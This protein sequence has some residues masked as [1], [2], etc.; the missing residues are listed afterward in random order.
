MKTILITGASSGFG[1]ATAKFFA[2]NGWNVIATMRNPKANNHGLSD[3]TNMLVTYLDVQNQQSIEAAIAQ[4]ITRFGRIDTV[5]N[6]AGYG[7]FGIFEGVSRNAIQQQFEVNVFGAMDIVRA[8]LPHFR[9]NRAGT[10]IN[11]SSGAGAIG[12]P[13]ASVY[14]AS[15]FALEG[16]SEGLSYELGSLGIKVK[17][18]E[19]GGAPQTGFMVRMGK[20]NADVQVIDSYLPFLQYMGKLYGD[21]AGTSQPDAVEKVVEAI[22]TAAT[23]GSSQLRYT[24]TQDIYPLLNARRGTSEEEYRAL[25]LGL[26]VP[27]E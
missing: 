21:M 27:Q 15:K 20:E 26:F 14:S 5:V 25:T 1:E 22:Y 12:F 4:G 18:I 19:P 17:I 6:N 8:I 16:W 13:M 2:T 10:I 7:L 9:E 11:V 3:S 24:P 23:D